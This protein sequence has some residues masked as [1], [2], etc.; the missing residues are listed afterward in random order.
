MTKLY[1]CFKSVNKQLLSTIVE[2]QALINGLDTYWSSI[3]WKLHI[4]K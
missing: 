1:L 3:C 4:F 2:S